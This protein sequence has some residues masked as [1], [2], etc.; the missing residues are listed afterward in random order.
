[1]AWADSILSYTILRLVLGAGVALAFPD[2]WESCIVQFHVGRG[3][4]GMRVER[5]APASTG[6]L[7]VSII[8]ANKLWIMDATSMSL[9]WV[10]RLPTERSKE[11]ASPFAPT[12]SRHRAE[13]SVSD[14]QATARRRRQWKLALSLAIVGALAGP[15]IFRTYKARPEIRTA[16]PLEMS[17]SC[18]RVTSSDSEADYVSDYF[19]RHPLPSPTRR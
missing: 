9:Y 11:Q 15:F 16:L 7:I 12:A 19:C 8:F 14:P 4:C 2:A 6:L 5:F 10:A 3:R 17:A 1:M 18:R 13:D